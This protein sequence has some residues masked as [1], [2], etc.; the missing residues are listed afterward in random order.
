MK[1]KTAAASV[2]TGDEPLDNVSSNKTLAH[3]QM[4]SFAFPKLSD[5]FLLRSNQS[6]LYSEDFII[7]EK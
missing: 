1:E 2:M 7:E 5:F 6:C 3:L 4:G